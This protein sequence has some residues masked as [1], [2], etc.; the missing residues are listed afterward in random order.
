MENN[1]GFTSHGDAPFPSLVADLEA[2]P[3]FSRWDREILEERL[4]T[5]SEFVKSDI[6]PRARA[7]SELIISHL[8]FELCWRDSQIEPLNIGVENGKV[9]RA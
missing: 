7:T 9:I 2:A 5:Y 4:Q 3:L 6:M 8:V 1:E